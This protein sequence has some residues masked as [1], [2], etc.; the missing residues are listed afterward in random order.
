M[1][2]STLIVT[3]TWIPAEWEAFCSIIEDP[4]YEK[5][6][7]YYYHHHMRL[8]M[9]PVGFDHSTNHSI[10]IVA[11]NL[12]CILN[13]IPFQLADNC[14]YRQTGI[15]ECQPDI[16]VYVAE[17][18]NIIPQG[19]NIVNI[20]QYPPPDLVVEVAKTSLLDDLGTKRSLYETLGV[21]EYWIVDVDNTAIIA[22][23]MENKGSYQ[24]QC[25]QVFLGLDISILEEALRQSR[26]S[27]QSAV[28]RWLMTQFQ[29]S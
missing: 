25:S 3:N 1:S 14:S 18:A 28:G 5:A 8:E 10:I 2:Y 20:D 4:V 7:A 24:I 19:T 22:Y 9:S 13:N 15:K 6:K 29:P 26:Q 23:K 16:S 17:Q 27:D 12:F 21:K 11:I